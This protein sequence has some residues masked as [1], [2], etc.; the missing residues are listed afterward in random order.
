MTVCIAVLCEDGKAAVVVADRLISG[1][2]PGTNVS[3]LTDLDHVKLTELAPGVLVVFSGTSHDGALALKKLGDP[4]GIEPQRLANKLRQTWTKVVVAEANAKLRV[5]GIAVNSIHGDKLA[6]LSAGLIENALKVARAGEFLLVV[7][8]VEQVWIYVVTDQN[9]ASCDQVGFA[10]IGS[11]SPFSLPVLAAK[12]VH[13]G[14][15]LGEWVYAAYEAKRI[16]DEVET[17]GRQA[18]MAVVTVGHRLSI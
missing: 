11:G 1:H 16:S 8:D 7:R 5:Y 17:V 15:G 10:A 6:N 18:D 4:R 12:G 9:S 2:V 3:L 13:K 14:F